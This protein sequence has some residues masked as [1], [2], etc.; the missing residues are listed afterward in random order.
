MKLLILTTYYPPEKNAASVRIHQIAKRFSSKE[1]I[2]H[3]KVV[4]F[5]PLANE[6]K[7]DME[8]KKVEVLRHKRK[9]IPASIFL[10]QS[11]NPLT[12]IVWICIALKEIIRYNPDVVLTSTPPFAPVIS[13]S[14]VSRIFNKPYVID[15][16]DDMTSIIDSIA[17]TKRVY[18][19]YPLEL[20][21]KLVSTFLNYALKNASL[22][23]TV[24]EVLQ[25]KLLKVNRNVIVVPNG[26]D[27]Q[28]L[29][30]VKKNFDKKEVLK[31]NKI[32]YSEN[33]RII[34]YVGDLD[35]PYYI[36][37][38]LLKPLEELLKNGYDLKYIIVGDGKRRKLIEMMIKKMGLEN[39]VFLVGKKEHHEVLELLL[40]GDFAFY[41]L[42]KDDPQAKHA[43]GVKVY[44]YLSCKLPI[45]AI[46][47][48]NSAV[49]NLIE[50]YGVGVFVSWEKV[51]ELKD[52]LIDLIENSK[53]Y[54]DNLETHYKYFIEKFDRSK[55]IDLLYNAI[56]N[57]KNPKI[58]YSFR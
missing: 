18:V 6:Y 7:K 49:S 43:I 27:T 30:E 41:S 11:L 28:E 46:A 25:K 10:P 33:C 2:R 47:D 42:Q 29:D 39:N 26:I 36:P 38:T 20:A 45:L 58:Q 35:M 4:V 15:Y 44:E 55:G 8:E 21:N 19:R 16:R 23:C 3:I 37:E 12:F 22:I 17:K 52:A 50:K 31:K 34:V 14:I 13:S 56:N 57:I 32:P 40:A 51:G 5:N 1:D 53:K 24:N 54:K 48:A 9:I